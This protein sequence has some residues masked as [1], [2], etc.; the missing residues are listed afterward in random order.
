MHNLLQD[1]NGLVSAT[2]KLE[3]S[4][5]SLVEDL[6]KVNRLLQGVRGRELAFIVG[7]AG[8]SHVHVAGAEPASIRKKL[9]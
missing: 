4:S 7:R 3:H 9:R 2:A 1:W 5:S 8:R 6:I